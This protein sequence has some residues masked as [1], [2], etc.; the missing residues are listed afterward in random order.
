[1]KLVWQ[2]WYRLLG[3]IEARWGPLHYRTHGAIDAVLAVMCT[4]WF[5]ALG[6]IASGP[7]KPIEIDQTLLAAWVQAIGSIAAVGL[8]AAIAVLAPRW[9]QDAKQRHA[10]RAVADLLIGLCDAAWWQA[11]GGPDVDLGAQARRMC[12]QIDW[13]LRQMAGAETIGVGGR[14]TW[15]LM[16]LNAALLKHRDEIDRVSYREDFDVLCLELGETAYQAAVGIG[17]GTGFRKPGDE[18]LWGDTIV[19]LQHAE[20]IQERRWFREHLEENAWEMRDLFN[21][22]YEMS[23]DMKLYAE[24]MEGPK[25]W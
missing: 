13:V 1:M 9:S 15:R 25:V 10:R 4:A 2:V 3:F 6:M 14:A 24:A 18:W 16:I 20:L 22:R 5:L 23:R 17:R 19:G 7:I 8:A 11:L 12:N 21:Q